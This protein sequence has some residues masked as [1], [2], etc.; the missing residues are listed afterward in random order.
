MDD[1]VWGGCSGTE[2]GELAVFFFL[3]C[4]KSNK[5]LHL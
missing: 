2:F 3:C 4:A 1:M 5:A